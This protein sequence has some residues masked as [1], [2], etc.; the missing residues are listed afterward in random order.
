MKKLHTNFTN[1]LGFFTLLVLVQL[2][3]A[4]A[5]FG[6]QVNRVPFKHRV[7]NPAPQNNIF[8]IKGDFT[9]IGNTSMT[10]L[11]YENKVD[12]S[13]NVMVYVDIDGDE[14]TVNSSSSSLVFSRENGADPSCSEIIYAGLYWSG[15][16]TPGIGQVFEVVGSTGDGEPVQIEKQ[17]HLV[18]H[19]ID[20]PNTYY[21]LVIDRNGAEGSRYPRYSFVSKKGGDTY[22]FQFTNSNNNPVRYRV[23]TSGS[24]TT[25][26]DQSTAVDGSLRTSTFE[27]ILIQDGGMTIRIDQFQRN[28]RT[29]GEVADFRTE[30][31]S[32]RITVE[33]VYIP[34]VENKVTLDK[35]KV[36]IKGP[37]ANSYSVVAAA[38]NQ[39]LFP[40]NELQEMY[41]GYADITQYVKLHGIGEYTVADLALVEGNGGAVGYFGQW[42]IIVV[43]ENSKMN[44]RDVT[45]FDGY[46]YMRPT[47]QAEPVSQELEISGFQA[48]ENGPVNLKLGVMV[49]E[50]D[51]GLSGDFFEIRNAANTEWV[52][53]QHA[54]NETNNFFN[55]SI[56]T[57]VLDEN[58]NLVENPRNPFL[59][60]STGIDI[61]MWNVPNPDNS[62]IA[63]GQTS[64]R[65]RYGSNEDT[66]S[67]YSIAFSVDAYVPEIQAF[68]QIESIKGQAPS[69]EPTVQPGQ[70]IDYSLEIKNLGTENVQNGKVIIPI[71]FTATFVSARHEVYFEPNSAK[72]PYFDPNFGPTG[73]IIWE[74]G[75]L[76]LADD[77][78]TV[79]AKLYYKLKTTEDCLILSEVDCD[80]F[81]SVNGFVS[82]KG[83]ISLTSFEGISLTQGFLDGACAGEPIKEAI[84]VKITGATEW[85]LENCS[86]TELFR[87]FEF[88]NV[89]TEAGVPLSAIT[90]SF[91]VGVRF[92]DGT[93]PSR[94]TEFTAQNPFPA[95]S[96]TYYAIPANSS[97]CVYEFRLHVTNVN[98]V[99]TI[100]QGLG[101][102]FCQ[103]A[104]IPSLKN[105]ILASNAGSEAPYSV[106]F[107]ATET[108]T[109]ALED[110][111]ADGS[112]LGTTQVWVAEGTSA[113]CLGKRALVTI[114]V[115]ACGV[116]LEKTGTL[117]DHDN[118]GQV[119]AGDQIVY[120]FT[121]K[122]TGTSPVHNISLSDPIVNVLG[123]PIEILGPGESDS[124]TF[125]AVYILTQTDIDTG[126]FT[127]VATVSGTVY[128]DEIT[129][130]DDDIQVFANQP[131]LSII[132]TANKTSVVAIGEELIY[133]IAVTNTGNVTLFDVVVRDPLTQLDTTLVSLAPGATVSLTTV[134]AVTQA[135]LDKGGILNVATVKA[136]DDLEEEG[137]VE[138]PVN[139]TS[140]ISVSKTANTVEFTAVGQVITYTISVT[141]TGNTTL[142]NIAVSDPLTGLLENVASL[143]P[144]QSVTFQTSYTV[145]L[146][147]IENG[148]VLNTVFVSAEDPNGENVENTDTETVASGKKSIIAN[149][150]AFGEF[151]VVYGGVLGNILSNDLLDGRA[152]NWE[153]VNFEIVELDGVLGLILDEK[154]ELSIIPGLNEAREYR[155]RYVLAEALNPTNTDDAF[156]TFRLVSTDIDLNVTKTSNGAE[157]VEGGEFEY[158]IVVRNIGGT[159]ASD[160]VIVDQLPN[161]LTYINSR[162]FTN[163]AGLQVSQ[164]VSGSRLTYR[165][166]TLPANG[167]VTI[168]IRVKANDLNGA[169]QL[170]LVNRVV[171][172]AEEN[173]TNPD[174]NE[175]EDVNTV[176]P[177]FI[178][179]VITPNNDGKNDRFVIQGLQKFATNE[180]VIMNR[181]GDHVYERRNYDNNWNADGLVGGTYFYVLKG[182]DSS[183]QMQEFKGWIQVI[184]E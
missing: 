115:N 168:H 73:A 183:G 13:N 144:G 160:V 69:A 134:Y 50:G 10:L 90:G 135:D 61:A 4:S 179:N 119:N 34:T 42:G 2:V 81:V 3:I 155:L 105:L 178:P 136:G 47:F 161:G 177:F 146:A 18:R 171:V 148:S 22:Q 75:D 121:I 112:V 163:P 94:A 23:G 58:N 106:Y 36:K 175:A 8:K 56:Y 30:D 1:G 27:P 87:D 7:G 110:F 11:D 70:E 95:V 125:S 76:P 15:R 43:Y 25:I 152:I 169:S 26:P 143:A 102:T 122:N 132:K 149:D 78:N 98:T 89:D 49:G 48:S 84:V 91:P 65:F 184:K 174:D 63:N 154:G 67:I 108:S 147:D 114:S 39:I 79:L 33:G 166:P 100:P 62:I 74:L 64:T 158:E 101:L 71:P 99:P 55:S 35:T 88:C 167:S 96:G 51:R 86:E 80:P 41:A 66:Y 109:E 124:T 82:G 140:S 113:D 145:T 93:D 107:F 137:S 165:V 29:E 131:G 159:P 138:V 126:S 54:L 176:K 28:T 46:S 19:S 32:A 116:E 85:V 97:N 130:T 181:Y 44:W 40:A 173:D 182:T 92:F 157:I 128:G 118:N 162:I 133:T 77:L 57:P 12:N 151:P 5:A 120:Q 21:T 14:T 139:Q 123:G 9:I 6:Q 141:N 156:I 129:A 20:L 52:R 111:T 68:N 16:A 24:Y 142:S 37:G 53:L 150:D 17:E 117:V 72:A 60:N 153:D 103:G 172:S 45:V 38:N 59:E 83:G 31:F 170:H 180:I 127:N 164:E 104:S